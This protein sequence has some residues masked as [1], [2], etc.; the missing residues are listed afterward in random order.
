[1]AEGAAEALVEAVVHGGFERGRHGQLAMEFGEESE[2]ILAEA[3]APVAGVK[4]GLDAGA[5]FRGQLGIA[6]FAE[7]GEDLRA[8]KAGDSAFGFSHRF[9]L[10]GEQRR[11]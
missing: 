8:A 7:A 2:E 4:V 1:V 10:H 9:L 11:G 5:E 6:K 3:E